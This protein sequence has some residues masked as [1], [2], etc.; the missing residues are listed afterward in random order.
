MP[1]LN[2]A[3]T[4]KITGKTQEMLGNLEQGLGFMPNIMK[5]MANSPAALEMFLNSRETLNQGLL[6]KQMIALIGIVV[7]EI[8]SCEY[9]LASRMVMAKKAGIS[10][11]E[12][13]LARQQTSSEKKRDL[14]LSFVRNIV[15][16]HASEMPATDMDDLK[17][18]GWT[19]GEIVE[20]IAHT[21]LNMF[22]YY[23]IQIGQPEMDFPRVP[24]AFP[25]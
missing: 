3:D 18:A 12:L 10:D 1:V 24:V 22:V 15:V 14:A 13:N 2:L 4:T 7:A 19:H 8:Y 11:E 5:Q 16:R 23:L 25:V 17:A 20:L 21:S 9:L 6:D